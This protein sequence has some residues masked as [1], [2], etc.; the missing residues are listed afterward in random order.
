M[1]HRNENL[2]IV[3]GVHQGAFLPSGKDRLLTDVILRPGFHIKGA[4]Y[5]NNLTI[6]GQGFVDGPIMA[7]RDIL[8]TPPQDL[9]DAQKRIV[10]RC[11]LSAKLAISVSVPTTFPYNPL[12]RPDFIPLLIRGDVVSQSVHLENALVVG[13]VFAT[14]AVIKD[15][16]ILGCPLVEN[17]LVL[18]NTMVISFRAA[19]VEFE[20]RNSLWVPYGLAKRGIAFKSYDPDEEERAQIQVSEQAAG[21][22]RQPDFNKAWVRYIPLCEN[23]THGCGKHNRILNCQFHLSGQCEYADVRMTED[24]IIR[25]RAKNETA[26]ALTLAPRFVDLKEIQEGLQ[27]MVD[28]LSDVLYL[29]HYS[30]GSREKVFQ[31]LKDDVLTRIQKADPEVDAL[32]PHFE[33]L[34]K[35]AGTALPPVVDGAN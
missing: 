6:E 22:S 1:V 8:I 26:Y 17:K 14:D 34:R 24:D 20:G 12:N 7:K 35:V 15:S 3:D 21:G 11:G 19:E 33:L 13:N 32:P 29:E 10:L 23:R 9:N 2:V 31:R 30:Q 4:L 25:F 16:I 28:L 27:D 18:R 5:A